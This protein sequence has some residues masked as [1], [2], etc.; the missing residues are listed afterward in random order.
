VSI[1]CSGVLTRKILIQLSQFHRLSSVAQ[2]LKPVKYM[3]PTAR[4]ELVPYPK[5][6]YG[7]HIM[8]E[9]RL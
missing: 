7:H 9:H 2:R 3:K 6:H 1:P 5:P 4:V 8:Q